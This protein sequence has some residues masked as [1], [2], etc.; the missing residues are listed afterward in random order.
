MALSLY[1]A[2]PQGEAFDAE[3]ETVVLPGVEGDFGVLAGHEAFISALRAG[4]IEIRQTDGSRRIAAVPGGFAEISGAG[5]CEF[6]DEADRDPE[7]IARERAQA[8]IEEM[9]D[10]EEGEAF[11]R[12]YQ[13][14]FSE[15]VSPDEDEG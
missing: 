10:T 5:R 4:G 2:T 12:Q 11:Y 15:A 13:E 7:E 8:M 14:A 6:A 1:I 3:V 9:R